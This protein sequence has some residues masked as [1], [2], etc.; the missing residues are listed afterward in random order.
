MI[1]FI[2]DDCDGRGGWWRMAVYF[3]AR[4]DDYHWRECHHCDGSGKLLACSNFHCPNKTRYA[5]GA[6]DR[7]ILK[8][9][10]D[11]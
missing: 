3:D 9:A 4:G 1:R 2:C 5:P 7:A 10:T 6:L 11:E 8:A